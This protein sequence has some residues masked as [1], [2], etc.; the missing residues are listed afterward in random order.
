MSRL[1]RADSQNGLAWLGWRAGLSR[2]KLT[3]AAGMQVVGPTPRVRTA[4]SLRGLWYARHVSICVP[5]LRQRVCD[6]LLGKGGQRTCCVERVK[7]SIPGGVQRVDVAV[8]RGVFSVD[9]SV[10]CCACVRAR[11]LRMS[12][13]VRER[14]VMPVVLSTLFSPPCGWALRRIT[15]LGVS[16]GPLTAHLLCPEN[17]SS[18]LLSYRNCQFSHLPWCH[19]QLHR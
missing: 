8:A 15:H 3:A 16:R 5:L 10:P 4:R 18:R 13:C 7:P 2:V 12:A 11:A 19:T 9:P 17:R 14:S 6:R 1:L